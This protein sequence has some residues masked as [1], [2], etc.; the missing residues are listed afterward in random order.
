MTFPRIGLEEL[1]KRDCPSFFGHIFHA[2]EHFVAKDVVKPVV[3]A[4]EVVVKTAEHAVK[5]A[6]PVIEKVGLAVA[7]AELG[8]PLYAAAAGSAVVSDLAHGQ[9]NP[10]K[11]VVDA[12]K[13]AVGAEVGSVVGGVVGNAAARAQDA[14]AAKIPGGLGK[15]LAA[16]PVRDAVGVT[17]TRDVM[18]G[19]TNPLRIGRDVAAGLG[20]A[21]LGTVAAVAAGSIQDRL[22]ESLPPAAAHLAAAVP[23]AELVQSTVLTDNQKGQ[24]NLGD[25]GRDIL[26]EGGLTSAGSL[27]IRAAQRGWETL[28]TFLATP[29]ASGNQ[30]F[31]SVTN[32]EP[33]FG[34]G[35]LFDQEPDAQTGA[36]FDGPA[37]LRGRVEV[38]V[39]AAGASK[40]TGPDSFNTET[41]DTRT[42]DEVSFVAGAGRGSVVTADLP[43]EGTTRLPVSGAMDQVGGFF[44]GAADQAGHMV[45]GVGSLLHG[46]WNLTAGWLTD[47]AAAKATLAHAEGV[48]NAIWDDPAGVARAVA[49]PYADDWRA[50]R[51]GSVIGRGV[52]DAVPLLLGVGEAGAAGEVGEAAGGLERVASGA[53]A[54]EAAAE[55]A[56]VSGRISAFSDGF[57]MG[58]AVELP[59]GEVTQDGFL[60]SAEKYLGPDYREAS[61]GRFVSSDGWRQVRFGRHETSGLDLH[62]HFEAY[63]QPLSEGGRVIE[64]SVVK[65][66]K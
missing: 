19:E 44:G 56:N 55:A 48:A 7:G 59:A 21:G 25:V 16:V 35:Q 1:E 3:H 66:V 17:V 6:A 31:A 34:P 11:I 13:A 58:R 51:Y 41:T 63:D 46:G 43:Q 27:A 30:P 5:V 37:V 61:S 24:T 26:R 42:P 47:P 15:L 60:Q 32:T 14:L 40:A 8:L 2:V 20:F 52:V 57:Q 49:A 36:G 53:E 10:L 50:G 9:H 12:G 28:D 65:V 54:A 45:S 22:V 4:A 33:T 23:A 38:R 39:P 62:A 64:N 18:A 29:N